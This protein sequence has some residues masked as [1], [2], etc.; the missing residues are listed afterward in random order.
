M[1]IIESCPPGFSGHT[2]S[3]PKP[4]LHLA[5]ARGTRR[6]RL[7]AYC[8]FEGTGAQVSAEKEGQCLGQL[9]LPGHSCLPVEHPRGSA[10]G[11]PGR[12]WG[13]GLGHIWWE[14]PLQEWAPLQVFLRTRSPAESRPDWWPRRD[15]LVGSEIDKVRKKQTNAITRPGA[16]EH[17]VSRKLVEMGQENTRVESAEWFG[18]SGSR[19]AD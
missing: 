18:T 12:L 11:P 15:A 3:V 14:G 1:A 2:H 7:S 8:C 10:P 17:S 16:N 19:C 9:L 4:T 5:K 6:A 13:G